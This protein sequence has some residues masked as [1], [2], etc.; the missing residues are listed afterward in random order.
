M[1]VTIC[2]DKMWGNKKWITYQ[3]IVYYIISLYV[4]WLDAVGFEILAVFGLGWFVY[5]WFLIF[6]FFFW[7][8]QCFL[9]TRTHK[10]VNEALCHRGK[11]F[12]WWLP[13]QLP[14]KLRCKCKCLYFCSH[15]FE[16]RDFKSQ[17]CLHLVRRLGAAFVK[18][19]TGKASCPP[20]GNPAKPYGRV[21][22][23]TFQL[24]VPISRILWV[25]SVPSWL[26]GH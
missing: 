12:N 22:V 2:R 26:F 20:S 10:L 24:S 25:F 13:L 1:E 17:S 7:Q 11:W 18:W 5:L 8:K 15:F 16:A 21:A 14:D 19:L 9:D 4:T 6:F 3:K 23:S